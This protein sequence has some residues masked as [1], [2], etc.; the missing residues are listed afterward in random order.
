MIDMGELNNN[1]NRQSLNLKK[2]MSL[3]LSK[4]N[5]K[6]LRIGLGWKA[7]RGNEYDLD[8]VALIL[9]DKGLVRDNQDVI[10]YNQPNT[11]RGVRSLGDNRTGGTGNNDD[12]TIL[13]DLDKIP[14]YAQK[15]LFLVTIDGAREK[16]QFFGSVRQSYI[17]V[18]NDETKEQQ[19]R[20]DV[21][22]DFGLEIAL[23]V[24]YLERSLSGWSFKA[25]GQ[26][27]Q[28]DLGEI[29]VRY[30]AVVG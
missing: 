9:D 18:L 1:Q 23:E 22:E 11:N 21:S 14:S 8:A 24:G 15:I 16:R 19:C 25:L 2:G 30:G 10:F 17:R 26:G 27:L 12:E 20:Y 7:G 5:L 3:N 6:K 29:L 4:N 13:V 28:E